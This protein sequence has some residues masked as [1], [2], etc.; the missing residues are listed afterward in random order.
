MNADPDYATR[1]LIYDDQYPVRIEHDRFAAEEAGTEYPRSQSISTI[2]LSLYPWVE[3]DMDWVRIF[4]YITGTVDQEL[5][6]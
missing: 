6:L 4:A 2:R 5:L 1:E 3:A